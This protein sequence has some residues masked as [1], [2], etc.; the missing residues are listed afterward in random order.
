MDKSQHEDFVQDKNEQPV[1]DSSQYYAGMSQAVVTLSLN[2]LLPFRSNT[3]NKDILTTI[4]C[5]DSFS[6]HLAVLASWEPL[7]ELVK[8][9]VLH[10][11]PDVL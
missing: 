10:H 4:V 5:Q 3:G 7:Y 9:N 6:V 8:V 1:S 2:L 11:V